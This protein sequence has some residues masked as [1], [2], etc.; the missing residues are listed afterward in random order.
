MFKEDLKIIFSSTAANPGF[1]QAGCSPQGSGLATQEPFRHPSQA[2]WGAARA[3]PAPGQRAPPWGRG[4][5]KA[6]PS[7]PSRLGQAG[8]REA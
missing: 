7:S 4:Q 6:R 3:A 8:D 1:H 5:A 2:G